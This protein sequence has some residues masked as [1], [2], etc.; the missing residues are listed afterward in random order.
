[1]KRIHTKSTEPDCLLSP[2]LAVAAVS[3]SVPVSVCICVLRF[4]LPHADEHRNRQASSKC[5]GCL[6]NNST[7]QYCT[8][9]TGVVLPQQRVSKRSSRR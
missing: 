7:R 4:T 9:N 8:I 3:L 2:E 1:M 5:K 6:A